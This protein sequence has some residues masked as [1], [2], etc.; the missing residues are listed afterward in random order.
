MV[1]PAE[2]VSLFKVNDDVYKVKGYG[3]EAVDAILDQFRGNKI[4]FVGFI[5]DGKLQ[6][7]V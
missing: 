1:Q 4:F 7:F 3:Q 5:I 2:V 6:K